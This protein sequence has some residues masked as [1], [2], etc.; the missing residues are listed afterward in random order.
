MS[1]KVTPGVILKSRFVFADKKFSEYINYIDRSEAVRSTGYNLY[2]VYADYMDNPEKQKQK[3]GFNLESERASALFT[4]TKDKLTL[5]EK[6]NLKQQFLK[7]QK[8]ESPIWQ[9]VISFTND[10][11]EENGLY[12]SASGLLDENKIRHITRLA[13]NEMLTNEK[14][15]AS[16]VWS[17]SIHFNTDNI[18]IH[19]AIVE[20]NPTRR[21]KEIINQKPDGSTEKKVQFKGMLKPKTFSKMKSKV[22]NNIVDRSPQLT[23]INEIIR[24]DIVKEKREK[25]SYKDKNL[26]GQF[27]NLYSELP[28]DRRLWNYNMNALKDVRPHIDKFTKM[29]IDMYH[30]KDFAELNKRLDEQQEFL[31]SVYGSGKKK[32][33]ENYKQTKINDLYTRMGNA[34]LTELRNYNN[35]LRLESKLSKRNLSPKQKLQAKSNYVSR[36]ESSIYNLKKAMNKD[37]IKSK[38]EFEYERLER[39]IEWEIESER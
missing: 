34:V 20:P 28:P 36:K 30:K 4:S 6:E 1:D 32:M 21:K 19:I 39:S 10:F 22:V 15:D 3:L 26:R 18:H 23:K 38:N 35:T 31:K 13:M 24:N 33:Y 25:N 37:Y 7:A 8:N 14:M 16:A 27:L 12:H 5:E 11:L 29:Y 2:S 17:A 9:N